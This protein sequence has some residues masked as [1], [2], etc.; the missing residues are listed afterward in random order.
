VKCQRVVEE[1]W[2]ILDLLGIER[3]RLHLKWVSASEG[4]IFA[5]EMRSFTELLRGLGRNPLAEKGF[6]PAQGVEQNPAAATSDLSQMA[7]G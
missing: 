4:N 2:Q 5:Q 7:S 3:Q 1:T 6:E